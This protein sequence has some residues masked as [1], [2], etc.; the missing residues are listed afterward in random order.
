MPRIPVYEQR[1]TVSNLGPAPRASGIPVGSVASGLNDLGRTIGAISA[2]MLRVQEQ[3]REDDAAIAATTALAEGRLHWAKRL[4]SLSDEWKEGLPSIYETIDNEMSDWSTRQVEAAGTER[5]KNMMRERVTAMRSDFGL[6]AYK[7]DR[8]K[9]VDLNVGR[10]KRSVQSARELVFSDPSQFKNVGQDLRDGLYAIS[11]IN[12][13]K[14]TEIELGV[15]QELSTAA[16]QGERAKVGDNAYLARRVRLVPETTG[17]VP[18]AAP[19]V[20]PRAAAVSG[21]D[22][23]VAMTLKHEGGYAASDGNTGAPVNFGINQAANPD[24]DVKNLTREGAVNL[25][26]DR[27]WNA[28]D[29]DK[30]PPA[31][32]ATAFDAAVNQGPGN[33]N[34]WI[35]ESGGDP[36]KFNQL[37]RAHYESLLAKPE[38]S[39]FRKTWMGRLEQYENMA[40]TGS[41]VTPI[42]IGGMRAEFLPDDQLPESFLGLSIPQR[43]A[44]LREAEQGARQQSAVQTDALRQ[45]LADAA[46]MARDGVVDP[47]PITPEEF[48]I[49]GDKA[50]GASQEYQRTQVM[51]QDISQFKTAPND[52]L[53][54]IA[55]GATR[56]AQP[57]AGYATEDQ[58]DEIRQQAAARVLEQRSKDP[59][60]YVSKTIPQ[61]TQAWRAALSAQGE[62]RPAIIQ[63]AVAQ[64]LAAQ[65]VL[66]I[67]EPRILSGSMLQDLHGRIMKAS[68]PEDAANMVKMLEQEYGKDYFPKV[69]DELVRSDKNIPPA[70]MIIPSLTDPAARELVSALS[71]VDKNELKGTIET[72]DV[73]AIGDAARK[74]AADLARTMPPVGASGI[75]LVASYQD[76]IERIAFERMRTGQSTNASSAAEAGY[77]LLLGNFELDGNIRVPTG[78]DMRAVRKNADVRL[79]TEVTENLQQSDVPPDISRAYTPAE[80]LEQWRGIVRSNNVWYSNSDNT[81]L[82]LWA[83][84]DDGVLYRVKQNGVQ[85]SYS[86]DELKREPEIVRRARAGNIQPNDLDK[87]RATGDMRLYERMRVEQR[88]AQVRRENESARQYQTDKARQQIGRP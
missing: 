85:I 38:F 71:V 3:Q 69:M 2:D 20:E 62:N 27:Y 53:I 50:P 37:R 22:A 64:T 82:D 11:E 23:V 75:R 56:R 35:A 14:K 33:A 47:K 80:A 87:A 46:A 19:A 76:M 84:G 70:F 49:L 52:Q 59:A 73:R 65:S 1:T 44:I 9:R 72:Q 67:S 12:E 32:Q 51:A 83:R 81:G 10:F 18:A 78:T 43:M 86:F 48:S 21:F 41:A 7:I 66:G 15:I 58:R 60:G 26:R 57:G 16:E 88:A 30:L 36:V 17:G 61:V 40:E 34:K 8:D 79:S 24:V 63:Q 28:I 74:Y 25:Y 42:T 55:T 39:R 5:S 31:L 29:G 54:G 77:A 6:N 45:R 68:R 4:Q 13:E